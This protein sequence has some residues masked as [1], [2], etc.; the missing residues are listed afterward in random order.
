[1]TQ[2]SAGLA[3]SSGSAYGRGDYA[4]SAAYG[5]TTLGYIALEGFSFGRL[6]SLKGATQ[7]MKAAGTEFSHWIPKRFFDKV[8]KS[9]LKYL[10][11]AHGRTWWNGRVVS[12]ME[13][14]LNDNYRMLKGMTLAN[15]NSFL[16]QQ[17]N[18]LPEW[19]RFV[20]FAPATNSIGK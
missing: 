17:V 12:S 7:G 11:P 1:M 3:E 19:A 16:R 5:V 20:I 4:E 15:K 9:L 10:G 13:H 6:G 14:A 2:I 18:R 8:P